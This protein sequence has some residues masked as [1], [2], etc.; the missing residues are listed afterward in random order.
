VGTAID[1]ADLG[2]EDLGSGITAIDTGFE[3]SM[4]DASHLLVEDSRAAFIDVG[5][6]FAAPRLMAALQARGLEADDVDYV[7][8][9]HVHLDHAGGAGEMMRR[10]P[11]AKLVVHPRGAR[12]M[13]DPSALVAG[14]SE[15]Y[16][17]DAV[18]ARYGDLVP[19]PAQ[20]VVEAPDGH[21]VE[22]KGR[23]LL[24]LD[25]PGHARHHLVI[26][27]EATSGFFTGDA[28][29][30]AYRELASAKGAF[31]MPATSPVQFEPDAMKA[32][33]S[34]MME[35]GPALLFLTHYSRVTNP[36]AAAASMEEMLDA[37]VALGRREDGHADRHAR[38]ARGMEALILDR[39]MAHGT[40]LPVEDIR[41]LIALDLELNAQGLGIW[42]DRGKPRRS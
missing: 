22:I 29:G 40:A 24:F 23:R 25:A 14:A 7:I 33:I 3:R 37:I 32:S 42:L 28:F 13:I 15:V 26:W 34:R 19:V 27:D 20:R 10:L 11:R 16:G 8:V 30:L 6:N 31:V 12:H 38:L 17:A 21:V 2:L 18:R 1:L 35:R 39:A 5:T 36:A 4:F 9:T 41:K